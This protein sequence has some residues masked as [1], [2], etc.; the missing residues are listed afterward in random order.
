MGELLMKRAGGG[1]VAVWGPSGLSR[2]DPA[3][4]LGEAFYR[5]V[6]QEGSGTLGL[7]ILRALRGL[8]RN[9]YSQDTLAIYNLLGDPALRIAGNTAGQPDDATFAQW[10]WQR[11]SPQALTDAAASGATTANFFDYALNGGYDVQ[12]EL[13]EFGYALPVAG[14]SG[15]ILRW[16]RRINRSDVDYQLFVSENLAE[17]TLE[18]GDAQTVGVEPDSD[19]V[20]ETV[21]TRVNRPWAE[22]VYIGVKAVR[23]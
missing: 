1:A 19:G 17:W 6:W 18:P 16:K 15:F 10:R 3:V 23:K 9:L 12:A 20:M 7:A 22:R 13:P 2:N 5:A 8:D 21:R 11:F 14:E 4:E